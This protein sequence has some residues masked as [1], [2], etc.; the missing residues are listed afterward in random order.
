[1]E[2]ITY[3]SSSLELCEAREGETVGD[4]VLSGVEHLTLKENINVIWCKCQ[5]IPLFFFFYV[6][7]SLTPLK[8][9]DL[10]KIP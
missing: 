2:L 9:D 3:V 10:P 6:E 1:M 5:K 8:H 4:G 7:Q